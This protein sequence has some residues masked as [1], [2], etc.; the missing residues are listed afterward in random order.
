MTA[1]GYTD[2]RATENTREALWDAMKRKE[3]YSTSGTRL[4]VR[5]FGGFDFTPEDA[6]SRMMKSVPS[7]S[8]S[9]RSR[10]LM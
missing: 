6:T 4:I 10:P 7:I 3:T 1:A 9:G 2:I 5:F 8:K